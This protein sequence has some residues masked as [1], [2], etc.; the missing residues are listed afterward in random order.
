MKL[1]GKLTLAMVL[2]M[3]AVLGVYG[4]LR[5][6][7]E[8]ATFEADMRRDEHMLGRAISAAVEDAWRRDGPERALQ[9]IAAA[10]D[11]EDGIRLRWV[12]LDAPVGDARR[13]EVDPATLGPVVGGSEVVRVEPFETSKGRLYTYVPVQL[14]GERAG[15]LE[16]S[17][18]LEEQERYV[19][20]SVHA[21]LIAGLLL[22]V[23][24]G[25]MAL[26]LGVFFVGRPVHALMDKARRIGNG[27]LGGP[28]T[29]RRRD[30]LSLLADEMNLMCER[31]AEART[32]LAREASA[33]LQTVE[34]LRH[35]DRLTTVGKL[36]SGIAHELGTPL[37]VVAGRA[38]MV[39]RAAP[40]PDAVENAQI[41]AEQADR[42]TKIIRQLLDF[43]RHRSAQKAPAD[44]AQLTK[45][46]LALLQPLA[47]KRGV[48]LQLEGEEPVPAEID[49]GQLQQALTNLVV[50]AIQSMSQGGRVTVTLARGFATPP[51]DHGGA[52]AEFIDVEVADQG[53]GITPENLRRIFEPFFT[54]KEVGEGTGLGLSVTY[55]IVR[56]HGGW[57]DVQSTPGR[58]SRFIMRLPAPRA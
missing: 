32:N 34:Q 2:V 54:T 38:K 31:L 37:N 26:A 25:V 53:A 18:S 57:I 11:R 5:V 14:D 3:C 58:G 56:E 20:S 42:M 55:G 48:T 9:I 41:I 1:V 50:N 15:A 17:E 21:T 43:A 44:L 23:M 10:N 4:Y 33:R 45:Q 24:S 19:Q 47:K 36:A 13:P 52:R 30:E 6:Q 27:D 51:P 7:Q 35:A 29:L 22:A 28:L 39:V 46:T 16:L 49:V 40:S 12:W 8:R